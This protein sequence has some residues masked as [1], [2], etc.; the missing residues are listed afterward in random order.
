MQPINKSIPGLTKDALWQKRF[1][2]IWQN[3]R[4]SLSCWI[5]LFSACG[6]QINSANS[7]QHIQLQNSL[8]FIKVEGREG[9]K[10]NSGKC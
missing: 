3:K 9:E 10:I 4:D 1:L 7:K 8:Q 6:P 5:P 2:T